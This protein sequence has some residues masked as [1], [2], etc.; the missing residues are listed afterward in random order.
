MAK[1]VLKTAPA[2]TPIV[3]ADVKAHLRWDDA[4]G[5]ETYDS[6]AQL[7]QLISDAIAIAEEETWSRF[8]TQT[9]TQYFDAFTDPLCLSNPP[10][11]SISSVK[12]QDAANAEQTLAATVYELGQENGI[13]VVRRKY[14][15][16]WPITL[17]HPDS[18]VVEF[19]CGYGLAVSVPDA[20]NQALK[21]IVAYL[22]SHRGD[23][24]KNI[25]ITAA[26]P[27]TIQSLLSPHSFR[28]VA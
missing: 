24:D 4:D 11:A 18:V 20:I 10:V 17:D 27:R 14:N 1:L 21:M 13:G 19:I 25:L 16:D 23:D 3:L 9:W 8:I 6:D 22:S 28:T 26:L 7:T 15:Q 2:V 5:S 12:Y